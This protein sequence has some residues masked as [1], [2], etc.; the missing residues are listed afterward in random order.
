MQ[1]LHIRVVGVQVH[2]QRLLRG[3][4]LM[5][6]VCQFV[7]QPTLHGTKEETKLMKVKDR[8]VILI[9]NRKWHRMTNIIDTLY[10]L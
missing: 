2:R 7:V 1:L 5:C 8:G 6:L 4:D 9:R 3:A 10:V